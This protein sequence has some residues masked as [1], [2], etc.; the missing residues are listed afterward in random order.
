MS[1]IEA[2]ITIDV[3]DDVDPSQIIELIRQTVSK[4]NDRDT[5]V[6]VNEVDNPTSVSPISM[7]K[8]RERYG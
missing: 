3:P 5:F 8:M 4:L 1:V 6:S 2:N 7:T